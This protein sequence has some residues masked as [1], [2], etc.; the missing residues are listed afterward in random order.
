MIKRRL[1]QIN[2]R[3]PK[4]LGFAAGVLAP[5]VISAVVV[6]TYTGKGY[7]QIGDRPPQIYSNF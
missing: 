4:L 2:F 3:S 6:V 7:S 1:P 5:I